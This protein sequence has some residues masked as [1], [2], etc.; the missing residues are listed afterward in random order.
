VRV[1]LGQMGSTTASDCQLFL[2]QAERG[3]RR[4]R[5]LPREDPLAEVGED[6]RDRVGVGPMEFKLYA[7]NCCLDNVGLDEINSV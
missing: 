1:R 6:V 5:R 3:S 4:T 7:T 2:S